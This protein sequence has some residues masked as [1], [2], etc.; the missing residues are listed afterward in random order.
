MKLHE[1]EAA[2]PSICAQ[3]RAEGAASEL[4]AAIE[5]ERVTPTARGKLTKL[6]ADKA[7]RQYMTE[8][9]GV[10]YMAAYKAIGGDA[11][12][13]MGPDER[14]AAIANQE[15]DRLNVAARTHMGDHPGISFLAAYKAVGGT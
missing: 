10:D 15:R 3:L 12:C 6:Q 7:A 4:A 9:A 8:H 14:S 1:L 11:A 5:R 13:L 2:Y